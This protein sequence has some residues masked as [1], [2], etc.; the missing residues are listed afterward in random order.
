MFEESRNWSSHWKV[1]GK[2]LTVNGIPVADVVGAAGGTPLYIY[3]RRGMEEMVAQARDAIG[4]ADLY[5]SIKANPFGPIVDFL[6]QLVDGFDV[7][8]AGEL[9]T[10]INSGKTG[11]SIQFSGPAKEAAE[12]AQ[13]VSA[14]VVLN[15]ESIGQ[16]RD[17]AAAAASTGRSVLAAIRINPEEVVASCGL[18]MSGVG[19]QFGVAPVDVPEVVS[20]CRRHGIEP[21]GF[22]FYWGTQNLKGSAIAAAQRACWITTTELAEVCQLE[23]RYLNLGGGFGIPYHRG[24]QYADLSPVRAGLRE[25]ET[26][27]KGAWPNARLLV[28]LGRFLVGPAGIYVV[29]VVDV[30]TAGEESVVI[31]DGG[32]HHHLAASGNLGQGVRR[33][34]PCL[35]VARMHEEPKSRARVVGRLCTPIDVLCPEAILPE[36]AEG[37][38]L[39]ILQSGAYAASASPHGFLSHPPAKELLL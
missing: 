4:G 7:A 20:Y 12:V 35:S 27:L 1:A 10:A 9:L 26:A 5:Y 8:S 38:L 11:E 37:D 16:A 25:I 31:T 19:S 33:S 6:A 21:I 34:Y 24:E 18:R 32:M 14:G 22:H 29:S 13:A 3:E 30:K 17:A 23:L 39:G 2:D 15:L 36:V 28:E